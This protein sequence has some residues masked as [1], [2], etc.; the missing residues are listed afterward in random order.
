MAG[1]D[2][3]AALFLIVCAVALIWLVIPAETIPGDEGE[4]PQA[5]MPTLAA[6][7]IL[8][9]AALVFTRAALERV[10]ERKT[11]R[12]VAV[13]VAEAGGEAVEGQ[14]AAPEHQPIDRV[15]WAVLAGATLLFGLVLAVLDRFG[16]L[17]GSAVA[18]LAF[19]LAFHR[20]GWRAIAVLAVAL[21]A[22]AYFLVLHVLGLALP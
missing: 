6:A 3:G 14:A 2:I 4:L 5:F 20:G 19:G 13:A 10:R 15:F 16:F 1:R 8:A 18:I 11:G 9:A 12:A 21:P 17:A 22:A 7:A